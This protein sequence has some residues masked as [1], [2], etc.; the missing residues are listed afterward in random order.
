MALMKRGSGRRWTR[1]QATLKQVADHWRAGAV[2]TIPVTLVP[3]IDGPTY[4]D[5]HA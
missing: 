2:Y 3:F 1:R 5:A 4:V